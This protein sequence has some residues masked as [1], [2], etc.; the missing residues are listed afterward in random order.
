MFVFVNDEKI[1]LEDESTG[2]DLA[3]KLNLTT[4]EKAIAMVIDGT[5]YDLIK[6][7]NNNDKVEF[8]SFTQREGK[9][10][11]WHSSAHVLAQA[12]LRLYPNAKPTIGPPIENGFF[13]DFADLEITEEDLNKI[14]KEVKKIIAENLKPIRVE[15]KNKTEAKEA[16]EKNTY[17]KTLIDEFDEGV[18]SAYKQGEFSDL[19]RGPH[20]TALT[21][22]KAFKILKMSGAYWRG[23][24]KNE[25]LTR[26]Y[27]ISFPDKNMLKDYLTFLEE[28]KKRDHKKIGKALSLYGFLEEAP[29]MPFFYPKGLYMWDTLLEYLRSLLTDKGYIEIKT[30]IMLKKELWQKSGHWDFYR[31]NMYTSVVEEKE[32]AIKPMNCPGCMLYYRTDMHSYRNLPL[33]VSEIGL[34]HRHEASGALNGLF[35]VRAFHQ[36]DAHVFMTPDQIKDQILEILS[37]LETI[38]MTFGLSYKLEL[39]TRPEK[40]KTIGTDEEWE[41]ATKGLKDALD[42]WGR[43]YVINEGDGAFYGPKIDIHIKD[44]LNRYWQCG[45]I[46]LDMSLP[47]KFDLFYI[48]KDGSQKR[49]VMI[50]RAILGSVERFLGI[51]TEHFAGNFPIWLSPLPVRIIAVADRHVDYANEVC[52]KIKEIDIPCDVDSSNESVSKKV[53]NAQLLKINYMLTVGDKEVEN[54]TIALRTRDNVVHG[55]MTLSKFLEKAALEK[56][57]KSLLS[58]FMTSEKK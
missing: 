54:S 56:N 10:I 8:L 33:K 45:T 42:E 28:A 34:V 13:Y 6:K 41:I 5:E 7:L 31:D 36:D 15:F 50:H 19:C 40:E 24:S 58:P 39:S 18:I 2:L 55:E 30:P 48:D 46:Q 37:L 1:E 22:I 27:G 44:A 9:D 52:S 47:E 51:L 23:D 38:Y 4:P 20:L 3:K 29:G 32:F 14:E 49:P 57:E 21:K 12:V 43:S 26:I 35:R 17:K 16:F 53:R 25:M 11:F